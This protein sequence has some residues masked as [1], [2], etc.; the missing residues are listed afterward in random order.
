MSFIS[1]SVVTHRRDI[2]APG[3]LRIFLEAIERGQSVVPLTSLGYPVAILLAMFAAL[4]GAQAALAVISGLH[5]FNDGAWHLVKMLSE[6]H[7]AIWNTHG[8]H[9]FYVGRFGTLF[10]QQYPTL[11][12]SRLHV[13]NPQVLMWIFGAT[14]YSFK[15]LSILLCY[16]FARDKRLVIFPLLTLVAVSMNSDAYIVSETH[17]MTALFWPALFG[18]LFVPEFKS[19]DLAAMIVVSVP[20]LLCYETMVA[21]CVFLCAACI[22]R[23]LVI[24]T[25]RGERWFTCLLFVWF[26]LG[27]I[28]GALGIIHPRDPTNR[29]GFRQ[30]L[31]F[32]F[33]SDHIGARVSCIV[34]AI[35]ALIALL[36]ERYR[37]TINVLTSIAVLA[38]LEIPLYILRHPTRTNFGTQ[39]IARTMNATVMLALAIAFVA[40]FF[41]LL[42][43]ATFQYSR[44]FLI[45]AILGM[46]QCAWM[47]IVTTQWTNMTMLLREELRT[48][49]GA[50][51]YEDSLLS[52][53][54][55][56]GQP[57][58]SLTA[59]WAMPA[60]SIVYADNRLVKSMVV[61]AP[62]SAT[63]FNPYSTETLPK[64]ER[65]G[66]N[67]APYLAA[68]PVNRPYQLDEWI[69][70]AEQGDTVMR[71]G[72]GWWNTEPWATW[73]SDDASVAVNFPAPV[74]SDLLL[75]AVAGGYVNEKNSD[76]HVQVLV[77][78]ASV[79][80]WNF[81]YKPG[82]E[83]YQQHDLLVSKEILNRQHPP[84][85]RFVISG[86]HSPAELG[87][88]ADPRKLGLA[89]VKMRFVACTGD[90]C[91]NAAA[92]A[93]AATSGK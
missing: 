52:Q 75:E 53:W 72:R 50:I 42:R 7:V 15:P 62:D 58:R 6:N 49:N 21:F 83:P 55:V 76:V 5:M 66:F 89:M 64:V 57:I 23:Y 78:N 40:V 3:R 59:D 90:A 48:H 13:R 26:A 69:S 18:L 70:F 56:D 10:Y 9:D 81:H 25:T 19:F 92:Q 37:K 63:A 61:A 88:G 73:S 39:V 60:L 44:L 14:L 46:C 77:N 79:G 32:M 43:P 27:G 36:P 16:R 28:F 17:L 87:L 82:A 24:A 93:A 11:L 54:I 80:E 85:I 8:W 20:L 74:D 68:L 65:F 86:A 51:P 45:A 29:A 67:Y 33:Q 35:C 30:N 34:L 91:S 31:F 41:H 22:Y 1:D 47:A 12:A 4:Y 71:K 84:V 2:L 38:S